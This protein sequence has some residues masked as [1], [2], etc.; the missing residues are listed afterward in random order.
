MHHELLNWNQLDL[1]PSKRSNQG[2]EVLAEHHKSCILEE[3]LANICKPKPKY[4][5]Q[6]RNHNRQ[7]TLYFTG[8]TGNTLVIRLFGNSF[9]FFVTK[10]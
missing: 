4:K 2:M 1:E 3:K 8:L 6:E 5:I 10:N 9:S 7:I